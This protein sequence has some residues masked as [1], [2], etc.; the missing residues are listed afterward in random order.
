MK[1]DVTFDPAVFSLD[2][3]KAACYKFLDRISPDIELSQGKIVC[4][5]NIDKIGRAHV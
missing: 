2:A 1:I 5:L 4:R 3:V